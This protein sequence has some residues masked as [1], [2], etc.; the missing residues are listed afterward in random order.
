MSGQQYT[1]T[2]RT[3][4]VESADG[5][6]YADVEILM[7]ISWRLPNEFE[8]S[9]NIVAPVDPIIVDGTGSGNKKDGSSAST[10][11]SHMQRVRGKS[12][13]PAASQFFDI[14]VCDAFTITGPNAT[15]HVVNCPVAKAVSNVVDDVGAG[16]GNTPPPDTQT[17]CQH[18]VKY[19][20]QISGATQAPFDNPTAYAYGLITDCMTFDGPAYGMPY[21]TVSA[22]NTDW[23]LPT[24][25]ID[26][27]PIWH[28]VY[29]L[30]F[31][32]PDRVLHGALQPNALCN[33][34]T[35]YVTDPHNPSGPLVPPPPDPKV[36][37][38]IYVYWP[39]IG[40]EVGGAAPTGTPTGGPFLGPATAAPSTAGYNG[41]DMGPIWWIRQIGTN[42]N[43]WFWYV[44]PVQTPLA[45]S[46]FAEPPEAASPKWGYRGFTLLPSFPVAWQVSA[47]YPIVPMGDI[48]APDLETAAAGIQPTGGSG[49]TVF[50]GGVGLP[51]GGWGVSTVKATTGEYLGAGLPFLSFT[52]INYYM[53]YGAFD[54]TAPTSAERLLAGLDTSAYGGP[55]PNIWQV[56]GMTDQQPPCVNPNMPF[57]ATNPH[58]QPSLALA[59]E[60]CTVFMTKWNVVANALNSAMGTEGTQVSAV[61]GWPFVPPPGW[62]WGVPYGGDSVGTA[63]MFSNGWV[64]AILPLLTVPATIPT[65]AIGQLDSTVWNLNDVLTKGT[66]PVL[67]TTGAP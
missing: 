14:E 8:I 36:D 67:W 27:V 1:R 40:N 21:V 3:V 19:T 26:I 24:P 54:L 33:D 45:W 62:D 64:P 52:L 29:G 60:V 59:E 31:D 44:S 25:D 55:T 4:R 34:L 23:D 38:N 32:S 56:T 37:L 61:T 35:H 12:N 48:G 42:V 18:V 46:F 6:F 41:I 49:I 10:R 13:T 17:R 50:W 53:P 51:D 7:A 16:L 66:P 43:V 63:Q 47:N 2:T 5:R 30:V 57:S 28:E 58:Q 65:I 9:Y 20:Q 39:G 22:G 11:S 15:E